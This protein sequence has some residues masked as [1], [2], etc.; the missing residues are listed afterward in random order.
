MVA[1]AL[2]AAAIWAFSA[3]V[4]Q[5]QATAQED[6]SIPVELCITKQLDGTQP[7]DFSFADVPVSVRNGADSELES[8]TY[9]DEPCNEVGAGW[10]QFSLDG[11]DGLRVVELPIATSQVRPTDMFC[12]IGSTNFE[13]IDGISVPVTTISPIELLQ[14]QGFINCTIINESVQVCLTKQLGPTAQQLTMPEA[15]RSRSPSMG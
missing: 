11:S 13:T 14:F 9:S 1:L 5:P 6:E 7:G 2:A 4:S 15:R 8:G 3:A 10:A 12:S